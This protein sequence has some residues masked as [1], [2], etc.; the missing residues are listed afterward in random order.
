MS[1]NMK[2]NV[3]LSEKN[4]DNMSTPNFLNSENNSKI[5]NSLNMEGLCN[6]LSNQKNIFSEESE[7]SSND[8]LENFTKNTIKGGKWTQEEVIK[9][10]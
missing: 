2:R 7:I 6:E 10:F 4:K 8:H 1:E 9:L 3:I 5:S